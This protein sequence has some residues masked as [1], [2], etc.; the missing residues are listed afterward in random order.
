MRVRRYIIRSLRRY[1]RV[2]PSFERLARRKAWRMNGQ[3][4]EITGVLR[5]EDKD[6][7]FV[8]TWDSELPDHRTVLWSDLPVGGKGDRIKVM[9]RPEPEDR[10]V[11]LYGEFNYRCEPTAYLT[12]VS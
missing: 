5:S 1:F 12:V 8:W 6:G 3:E 2:G 4:L 7:W 11:M 9:Y 10:L